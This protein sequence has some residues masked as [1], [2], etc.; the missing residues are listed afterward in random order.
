MDSQSFACSHC[1]ENLVLNIE[2]IDFALFNEN[3]KLEK[4][5]CNFGLTND[6]AQPLGTCLSDI[7]PELAGM[8][9]SIFAAMARGE[10]IN[11]QRINRQ[12]EDGQ[13][14][15][16]DLRLI[17]FQQKLLVIFRD[18]SRH[19]A[20]EQNIV[21]QRNEMFL[22]N[23]QLEKSRKALEEL[24]GLDE[25]TQLPNR[26]AANQLIL[27]KFQQARLNQRLLSVIF[28]DLDN[29]KKINDQ[30]GHESGDLALKFVA[31]ILRTHTRAED[32]AIRW[33]GDEFVIILAD[34]EQGGANR[35]A[36]LLLS[37]F[38]ERPVTLL[39][40]DKV[41]IKAS[42]GICNVK[43]SLLEKVNPQEVIHMADS[44]MYISKRNGGKQI[45]SLDM[46]TNNSP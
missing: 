25:L 14:H 28:F 27:H 1:L 16:V 37:V 2:G 32:T 24:S 10:E 31:N 39:N 22:L 11:I 45:T 35:I 9:D 38:A 42:I 23:T 18:S 26:R 41:H 44:A 4:V 17:P 3:L 19:G 33:G 5:C 8:E 30:R 36:S 40:G 13:S 20:L 43:N 34:S 21:Q 29:F 15:Y 46:G 12:R 7:I 6:P